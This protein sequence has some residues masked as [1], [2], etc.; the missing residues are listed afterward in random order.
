[1]H[2]PSSSSSHH[3]PELQLDEKGAEDVGKFLTSSA[4]KCKWATFHSVIEYLCFSKF[5]MH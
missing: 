2:I 4:C 3:F 5:I 1:M